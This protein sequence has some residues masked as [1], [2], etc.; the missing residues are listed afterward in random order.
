[1]DNVKTTRIFMGS[2][3]FFFSLS[4]LSIVG[5]PLASASRARFFGQ[6]SNQRLHVTEDQVAHRCAGFTSPAGSLRL[7]PCHKRSM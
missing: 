2:P 1:M 3:F 7:Q 5:E 6:E 4:A